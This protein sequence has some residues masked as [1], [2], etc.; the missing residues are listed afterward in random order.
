VG[1]L[2][3]GRDLAFFGWLLVPAGANFEAVTQV[4]GAV[5]ALGGKAMMV[6]VALHALAAF[7]HHFVDHDAVLD[8]MFGAPSR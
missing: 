8:R 3:G 6:L 1:N 7:E 2:Y 4:T 5:Y